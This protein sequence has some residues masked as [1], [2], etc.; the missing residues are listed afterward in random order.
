VFRGIYLQ[1]DTSVVNG[2]ELSQT[3]CIIVYRTIG[4]ENRGSILGEA[5]N[6]FLP[7]RVQTCSGAHPMVTGA[8]FPRGKSVGSWSWPLLLV[9]RSRMRDAIPPPSQYVFMA[10]C[11]VRHLL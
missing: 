4:K 3:G 2:K 9:P 6:F 8:S 7:H 1:D 11:L 10:P 5:G